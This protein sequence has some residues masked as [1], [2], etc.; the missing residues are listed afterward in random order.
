[1]GEDGQVLAL[2]RDHLACVG[3]DEDSLAYIAQG[4]VDGGSL[5]ALE[6]F[7][8]FVQPMLEEHCD[9]D[10]TQASVLAEKLHKVLSAQLRG[11]A[12]TPMPESKELGE[13]ISLGSVMV[14]GSTDGWDMVKGGGKGVRGYVAQESLKSAGAGKKESSEK[15]K[16]KTAKELQNTVKR[17]ERAEAEAAALD[18]EVEAATANSVALRG[19][20]GY[21]FNAAIKI[22]PFDLPHP[23]GSGNLLD[24]AS[25]TLTP[26]RRYALIGRNG[27]GK[28][29][30]LRNL[31]ARRCGGLPEAVRTHYVAQDV[32]LSAGALD[33]TP[34]E[35]VVDAD[36]ERRVLLEE[37]KKL[38]GCTAA[39]NNARYRDCLSQLEAIEASSAAD[40][41]EQLLVNL[42]FSK[43]LLSR[44][45]KALSGGW[46]V[47]VAL[48]A[49]LFAKPDILFLD[50]PTNHLSMQA[51]LWLG[52]ELASSQMWAKRIV[53]IVSHDRFFI[54][55][56]CTDMLHISGIARRLTQSKGDYTSWARGRAEQQRGFAHRTKV[57]ND[58][59]AKCKEYIA[60]GQAAAGNTASSG[61]R[62]QIEKLEREAEEE[63]EEL[64][65]LLEDK[66]LPL[67]LRSSG[68]LDEAAVRL[69]AVT[70]AYPGCQPLFRGVG[71]QPY[72]FIV[73]TTSRHVLVGENGNGKTTLMKLLLGELQPTEGE[74]I[75][76][77][78]SK[79]ALVNQ[80][81]AD[82]I[83]LTM[84]P[85]EFV[86]S[87]A[88]GDGSEA[89]IRFLRTELAN[90]GIA[91]ALHD[92]PAA[93]LSGGQ[94][95]R[96]AMV[97][98]SAVKPHV[99][100]MD[101]PTNNLDVGAVEALADAVEKFDGGVVLVSHDKY[102]VSRV[103]RT[104]WIVGN[105]KVEPC[106]CGFEEYWAKMLCKID[107]TST[108][109]VEALETYMR[110]KRVSTAYLS[111]GQASRQALAKEQAELR[112][113]RLV[114]V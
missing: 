56:T 43:E 27:R 11:A 84:S 51:V 63:A 69:K 85:L 101:E 54:D 67:N 1:M 102:F 41:A 58:E 21:N 98:V 37:A 86:R 48:A 59:I 96:L 38:E 45:M 19:S 113:G 109:A 89:H 88:P 87:K 35:V 107:P 74:V 70:F 10:E 78:Q 33:Q 93:A 16:E 49:A 9:N 112:A 105:G 68:E 77:R 40:R 82:Q 64:K 97:A 24:N 90:S 5:L 110:K 17:S 104:V 12:S 2:C 81:H 103:A 57:R 83:D 30:L 34:V 20:K 75:R 94:K 14:T 76:N 55:E 7:V 22:G 39:E 53:V 114:G 28:S 36:V 111:G 13:A 23:G 42:G 71:K 29:T 15:A 6:D 25:F 65:A 4:V 73:D 50:E 26:G 18:A 99:L 32:K 52:H 100:F 108:I 106:S 8:E 66:D 31:A 95:S 62:T 91:T 79:F 60:S 3:L 80:H 46:R 47:R 72:E 92:V 44:T 61:R